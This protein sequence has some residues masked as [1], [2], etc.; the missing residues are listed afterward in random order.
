M[1]FFFIYIF[2]FKLKPYGHEYGHEESPSELSTGNTFDSNF[3]SIDPVK[4]AY[5]LNMLS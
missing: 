4:A 3:N 1:Q 5:I 2:Y